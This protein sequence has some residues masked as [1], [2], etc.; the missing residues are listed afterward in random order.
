MLFLLVETIL[1]HFCRYSYKQFFRASG[2]EISIKSFITTSV[3]ES[4]VNF[5][6][7]AFIQRFFF[8]CWKALLKLGINQFSSIFLVKNSGSSFFGQWKRIFYRMLFILTSGNGF[9]SSVLLFTANFV[10]VK[11][12]IQIKVKPFLVE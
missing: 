12:I 11:T 5:K 6:Q 8:C 4:W 3:Y 2:N 10:L 9:L 7:C 1:L